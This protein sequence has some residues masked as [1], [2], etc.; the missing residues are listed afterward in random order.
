MTGAGTTESDAPRTAQPGSLNVQAMR[1]FLYSI[2]EQLPHFVIY[3]HPSDWPDFYVA[4]LWMTRPAPIPSTVTILETD[5]DRLRTTM[6]ALGLVHLSRC[7]ADDAV[8]LET[9]I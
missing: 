8:I 9:W 7:P 6:E 1:A 2:N 3:D 4:R 5:L